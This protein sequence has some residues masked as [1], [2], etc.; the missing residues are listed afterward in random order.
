MGIE[1][2]EKE[3]CRMIVTVVVC[4]LDRRYVNSVN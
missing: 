1:E 3:I 4:G 2:E